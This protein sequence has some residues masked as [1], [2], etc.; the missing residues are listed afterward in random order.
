MRRLA[1][2]ILVLGLASVANA[3]TIQISAGGN[4]DPVSSEIYL[5]P[6]EEII[7]DIHCTSG[8]AGSADDAYW[9]L[10]CQTATGTITGGVVV[11]P[12]APSLSTVL[13]PSAVGAGLPLL[14]GYDGPFGGIAGAP[15]ET[16][17]PGVYFNDFIFHC[18]ALG[19]CIVMLYIYDLTILALQDTLIIH[20]IPEP[21][22]MLLLGLGGLL[23]RR[24][25]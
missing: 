1:V 10:V 3:V 11:I 16:A 18:E 25:K 15:G 17:P 13:G 12:P 7:L 5:T 9:G 6:S 8:Y 22:S 24:R 4:P 23:I 14:P 20:Q 19:D 2:L 21:A